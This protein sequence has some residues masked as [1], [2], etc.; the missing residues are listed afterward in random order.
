MYQ[1]LILAYFIYVQVPINNQKTFRPGVIS[2]DTC[3][4]LLPPE[5]DLGFMNLL[6]Y[7]SYDR[8]GYTPDTMSIYDTGY[9]HIGF[10]SRGIQILFPQENGTYHESLEHPFIY[11]RCCM[12]YIKSYHTKCKENQIRCE[13]Y[14]A[15]NVPNQEYPT[16]GR[17]RHA[18]KPNEPANCTDMFAKYDLKQGPKSSKNPDHVI[19]SNPYHVTQRISYT[20]LASIGQYGEF[21]ANRLVAQNGAWLE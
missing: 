8:E 2:C 20:R 12:R 17:Y 10:L 5:L 3:V 21:P 9:D 13:P 4:A 18:P 15:Y 6:E 16:N 19:V 14:S 11:F 1:F 7:R